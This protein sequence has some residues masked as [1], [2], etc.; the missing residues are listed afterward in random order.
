[1]K[2]VQEGERGTEMEREETV[3]KEKCRGKREAD[4]YK[5]I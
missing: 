1:M 2:I 5:K 3:R 4:G